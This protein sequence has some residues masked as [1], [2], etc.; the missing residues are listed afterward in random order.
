MSL[1][2]K[3]RNFS[4]A[5]LLFPRSKLKSYDAR[6]PFHGAPFLDR[7]RRAGRARCGIVVHRA[8]PHDV[9]AL[10]GHGPGRA[11]LQFLVPAAGVAFFPFVKV[12]SDLNK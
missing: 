8:H 2:K 3:S 4:A 6:G 5:G 7:G 1:G 11:R 10:R 9:S 12:M